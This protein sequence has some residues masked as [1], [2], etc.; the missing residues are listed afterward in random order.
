MISKREESTDSALCVGVA[1]ALVW[2]IALSF[3]ALNLHPGEI[4]WIQW[5]TQLLGGIVACLLV[6]LA[7]VRGAI[8]V[9]ARLAAEARTRE[10]AVEQG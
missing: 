10:T 1:A 3:Y 9:S 6:P 5:G 7:W 4:S 2:G 8:W